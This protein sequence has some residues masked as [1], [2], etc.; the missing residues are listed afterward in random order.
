MWRGTI[1]D[2]N[3]GGLALLSFTNAAIRE[4]HQATIDV[5]RRELLT[6]PNYIG[7]FDSFVERFI[8][9]PFGHLVSTYDKRPRLFVSP[10]PGDRKN[11]NLAAWTVSAGGKKMRVPAWEIIPFLDS[12][13]LKFR[14]SKGFGDKI[15]QFTAHNPVDELFQLGYYTHAQRVYLACRILIDRPYIA[16]SLSRR[17]PEMVVDEAQD[18]NVWLLVLLNCLRKYG[19]CVTLIGDPDQ[20]IYEFSMADPASILALKGR[21]NI[22]ERPLSRSFRCNDRIADSV[23]NFGSNPS[24]T[25][26]GRPANAHRGPFVVRESGSGF[27]CTLSEFEQL[28]VRAEVPLSKSVILCRAHQQLETIRGKANYVKLRGRTKE[29]AQAAFHRDVR[30]DYR[31]AQQYVESAVR[32]MTDESEIWESLDDC[33]DCQ[34]SMQVRKAL[35]KFTKSPDGLPLV[36]KNA[37]EWIAALRVGL[38][39]LFDSI[40]LK[41]SPNVNAK[42]KGTGIDTT[43]LD[44]PLFEPQTLFPRIRQETIHQVKGEGIDGV[45]VLGSTKFFNSVVRAIESNVSTED[46]RLAYVALSRARHTL[47]V[48]LPASHYDKHL[49]SWKDWGFDV[50]R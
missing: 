40:G 16:Q 4:F 49:S 20:C 1:R 24:F 43:Q 45:L 28:L 34:E 12:G 8:V 39:R 21:W 6:D 9:S 3:V 47:L 48:G 32:A 44:L 5:G 7:T 29:L 46:R 35:W 31:R 25:G 26:S 37:N 23:R 18:T 41:D 50:L 19:T 10:R 22:P 11:N 42:V 14:T 13:K 36:S 38:L 30:N 15:L 17:F 2:R 33:P 27:H